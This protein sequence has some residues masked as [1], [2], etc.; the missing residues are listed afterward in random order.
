MGEILRSCGAHGKVALVHSNC[1]LATAQ[2]D[3]LTT[4]KEFYS[5]AVADTKTDIL[6]PVCYETSLIDH[7]PEKYRFRGYGCGSPILDAKIREGETVVDLGCGGGVECFVASRLAGS[8]GRA[9]GIDMLDPMLNLAN[10]AKPLVAQ[11][12][13]YDN[14]EFKKGYLE[15]LPLEDDCADVAVSNCVMNLSVDKRK[16]Y[17]EIFRILRPGGRL[18]ISDVVCDTEPDPAIRNDEVLKGECIA[19]A[20]TAAHLVALLEESGFEATTLIKRFP[21]RQV[22]GYPFFLPDL[23]RSQTEGLRAGRCDLS[24]SPALSDD[25]KGRSA[26]EGRRRQSGPKRGRPAGGPGFRPGPGRLRGEHRGGKHLRLLCRPGRKNG[27]KS[28]CRSL[29]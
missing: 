27:R 25:P 2:N 9:V 19:G 18:V 26:S 16:A 3:S 17:A 8:K 12:L 4:V 21:Y 28:R 23:F 5:D 14:I 13:G 1:L 6:N 10:E 7:I 22:D 29:P 15:D 24:R 11:N 20:L